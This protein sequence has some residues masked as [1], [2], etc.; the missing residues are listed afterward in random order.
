MKKIGIAMLIIAI[1]MFFNSC[2]LMDSLFYKTDSV[3]PKD[4]AAFTGTTPTDKTGMENSLNPVGYAVGN[5]FTKFLN[6]P[7]FQKAVKY[8]SY[9][10]PNLKALNNFL[11][12]KGIAGKSISYT[13]DSTDSSADI[14]V[15]IADETVD[16]P[17]GGT[18]TVKKLDL[19]AS[20][21]VDDP[22]NPTIA[23]GK[24]DV[25]AKITIDKYA[26]TD[27]GYTINAGI[28][29]LKA[30]GNSTINI[31]SQG[32]PSKIKYYAAID[33]NAGFSISAGDGESGKFIISFNYVD[34]NEL[35]QEQ[36]SSPDPSE[37]IKNVKLTLTIKVYDNDN[38][39]VKT[40][41]YDEN[42]LADE[43]SQT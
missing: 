3:S 34:S 43:L 13:N 10:Y 1:A 25:D 29:N 20:G 42:D 14:K 15:N 16:G 40:Y 28:I 17:S 33:L 7:E 37:L 27:T 5:G 21:D 35:T 23:K 38:N 18:L 19:T 9:N 11:A 22:D 6:K 36:L 26:D 41:S 2:Q 31:D 8:L 12:D 39:L 24:A 30:K 32:E 4:L